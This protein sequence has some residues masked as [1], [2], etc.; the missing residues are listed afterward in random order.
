MELKIRNPKHVEF[1]TFLKDKIKS[2]AFNGHVFL[3]G[4]YVRDCLLGKEPNDIDIAVDI[5]NGGIGFSMWLAYNTGCFVNGS[6]P[7]IFSN[8]G[9]AKLSLNKMEK[10]SGIEVEFV[11]TRK[12]QYHKE[13]RNP[14]T[15]FGSIDE[16]ASRRDF[17]I[18]ALY[19]DITNDKILDPTKKGVEDLKKHIIRSCGDPNIIFEEDPLRIIRAVRFSTQLGWPIEKNTWVGMVNNVKRVGILSQE[20]VTDE[21]NKI[22]LSKKPSDG[23]RKMLSCGVL[24]AVLPS[25][26]EYRAIFQ[27]PQAKYTLYD[28]T[29]NTLDKTKPILI[30]RLGALFH[31]LGKL[32]TYEKKF[33]Y[34]SAIGA[35]KTK[36][37]LIAM[38][39]SKDLVNKVSCIIEH[40]EDFSCFTNS[41][42]PGNARIRKFSSY[43]DDEETLMS[44]LD[45]INADATSQYYTKK[46]KLVPNI[47]RKIREMKERGEDINKVILPINGNDIM[48]EFNV[49]KGPIIGTL[50]EEVKKEVLENPSLSKEGAFSVIEKY[51]KKVV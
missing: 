7:V 18:N 15:V 33:L 41:V 44:A 6:N 42:I 46:P 43:F 5:P 12:E 13:N 51:L 4:G 3:V 36:E 10:F 38:K 37:L 28:H 17:T 11:Q 21:L 40:H 39:Y 14:S 16:D 47:L 2:S 1:I 20:R 8:F 24:N 22:L 48:A 49:K 32:F 9:T 45:V 23:I 31:D 25:I 30:N 26:S 27:T 19:Y 29:L 35:D 34:H 50:L